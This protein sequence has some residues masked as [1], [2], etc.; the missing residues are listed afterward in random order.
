[1]SIVFFYNVTLVIK[2]YISFY[3]SIFILIS[4]Y[5]STISIKFAT[6]MADDFGY[7]FYSY[8]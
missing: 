8:F 4:I 2:Y 5:V 1:M 6:D 3:F 7:I